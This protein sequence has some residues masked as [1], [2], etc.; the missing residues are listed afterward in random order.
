MSN[1]KNLKRFTY[2]LRQAQDL[3]F[4][5]QFDI[6]SQNQ[7]IKIGLTPNDTIELWVTYAEM[8]SVVAD[9]LDERVW[10]AHRQYI[11]AVLNDHYNKFRT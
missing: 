1:P 2:S 10:E 8:P 7:K 6:R 9:H 3:S 5:V 11:Y 4:Y